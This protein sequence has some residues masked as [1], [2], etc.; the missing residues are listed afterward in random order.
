LSVGNKHYIRLLPWDLS[1]CEMGG[2]EDPALAPG[3]Q[4]WIDPGCSLASSSPRP[5]AIRAADEP[6]DVPWNT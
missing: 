2:E 3:A 5:R 4:S 1:W 6:Q